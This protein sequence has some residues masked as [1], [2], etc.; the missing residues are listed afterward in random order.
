MSVR[1]LLNFVN[2]SD[3]TPSSTLLYGKPPRGVKVER[4]QGRVKVGEKAALNQ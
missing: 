2:T 3:G 4:A 1:R